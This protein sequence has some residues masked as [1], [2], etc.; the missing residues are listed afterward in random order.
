MVDVQP[1]C[2]LKYAS[3]A[4]GD[5]AHVF[6]PPHDVVSPEEQ[7]YYHALSPYN[8]LQV[9]WGREFPHDNHLDNRYTRSAELLTKWRN[10]GILVKD[11]TFRYYLYQQIFDVGGQTYTR[12]SLI[13]RV[14]L[15]SGDS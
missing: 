6:S 12:I 10:D 11:T 15:E 2:G 14:R 5:L 9:E 1:L 8:I 13:A 4:V 7:V 3:D